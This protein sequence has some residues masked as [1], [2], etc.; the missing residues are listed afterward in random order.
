M[1]LRIVDVVREGPGR[2]KTTLQIKCYTVDADVADIQYHGNNH[3]I[4]KLDVIF[5]G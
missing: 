1:Y 4:V 5:D 2:Y 3:Q